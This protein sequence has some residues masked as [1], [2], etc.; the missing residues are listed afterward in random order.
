MPARVVVFVTILVLLPA[1]FLGTAARARP[2]HLYR[3]DVAYGKEFTL[4]CE[5]LKLPRFDGRGV[6]HP[7]VIYWR[8]RY[9]MAYTPYPPSEAENIC[10][11]SSRDLIHWTTGA[12]Q[13]PV[14]AYDRR[15]VWKDAFIADPDIL[16][17]PA[18]NKWFLWFQPASH[19]LGRRQGKRLLTTIAL[20]TSNDGIEW[21]DTEVANP[22]MWPRD[23]RGRL[24]EAD[25][26]RSPSVLYD[27]PNRRFIMWFDS[28][29]ERS[30]NGKQNGYYP[31]K[32]GR[33]V[34]PDGVNWTHDP[35]PVVYS[36]YSVWHPAVRYFDGTYWMY[37]PSRFGIELATSTDGVRW[38]RHGVVIPRQEGT[39]LHKPYRCSPLMFPRTCYLFVSSFD[40]NGIPRIALFRSE[41]SPAG[42]AYQSR[43]CYRVDDNLLGGKII[44]K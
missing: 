42:R 6:V 11:V 28:K 32:I 5:D 24:W 2:I 1:A 30:A 16:Y 7:D 23:N 27:Q 36:T 41:L 21:S 37:F 17:V 18:L 19:T 20:A 29:L 9:I 14:V 13:N 4:V 40:K 10:L 39:W 35:R 15:V 22:V 44:L 25:L 33:A 43:H 34:S 26:I 3:G 12:W 38:R 8:G 31:M